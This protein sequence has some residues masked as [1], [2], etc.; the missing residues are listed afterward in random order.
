[1]SAKRTASRRLLLCPQRG[2]VRLFATGRSCHCE[3]FAHLVGPWLPTTSRNAGE[4]KSC[5]PSGNSSAGHPALTASG[6]TATLERFAQAFAIAAQPRARSA[7]RHNHN[8]TYNSL[9]PFRYRTLTRVRL[10]HESHAPSLAINRTSHCRRQRVHDR[11]I[12][13]NRGRAEALQKGSLT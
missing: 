5:G 8:P 10:R 2:A 13:R 9:D 6:R 11:G 7:L 12:E 1:M 4:Q 3:P